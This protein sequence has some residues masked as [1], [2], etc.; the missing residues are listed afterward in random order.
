ML[1]TVKTLLARINHPIAPD[2]WQ[3]LC[4]DESTQKILRQEAPQITILTTDRAGSLVKEVFASHS[5][6]RVVLVEG[7][8]GVL[9]NTLSLIPPW[10]RIRVIN[11]DVF[12]LSADQVKNQDLVLAQN[13]ISFVD[14]VAL[15]RQAGKLLSPDGL[16]FATTNGLGNRLRTDP[17]L[18][19]AKPQLEERGITFT[20]EPLQ[21]HSRIAHIVFRFSYR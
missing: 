14:S 2:F 7:N 3:H 12:S 20:Q 17:E 16:F 10:A 19:R 18:R 5:Q 9:T 13:F 11:K 1:E 6:A 8:P 4:R 15:V 21:T